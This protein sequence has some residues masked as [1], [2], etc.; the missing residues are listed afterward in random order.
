MKFWSILDL[1]YEHQLNESIIYTIPGVTYKWIQKP[2]Q[3]LPI[4]TKQRQVVFLITIL[5]SDTSVLIF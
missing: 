3:I 1:S 4:L 5:P 2:S